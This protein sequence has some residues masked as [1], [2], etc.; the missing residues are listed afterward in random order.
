MARGNY[1]VVT[2]VES[3]DFAEIE[4]FGQGDDAGVNGLKP[5]RGVAG[6]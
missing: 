5:E 1:E 4:A 6:E 3:G 2:L